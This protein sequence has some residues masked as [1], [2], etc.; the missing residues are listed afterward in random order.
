MVVRILIC[1]T[2]SAICAC[3]DPAPLRQ[4]TAADHAQP[5]EGQ[6][7]PSRVPQREVS[8]PAQ[9]AAILWQGLCASCHGQKGLGNGWDFPAGIDFTTAKWQDS[10]SDEQIIAQI[11]QGKPPMPAFGTRLT[12]E[13]LQFLVK[14]VR[15]LRAK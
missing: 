1:L 15:S 12:D 6:A 8:S 10:L 4:W 3:A 5:P 2:L 11:K 7:D 9:R 14:H 13:E